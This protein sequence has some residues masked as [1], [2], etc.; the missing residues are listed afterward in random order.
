MV[1]VLITGASGLLGRA[2]HTSFL[3][4]SSSHPGE[5]IEV[6]GTSYT[7][8]IEGRDLKKCDLNDASEVENLLKEVGPEVVIHCAAERRPDVAEKNPEAVQKLNVALPR[9]LSHL[10]LSL[11]FYLIYISTDYVFPGDKLP[12]EGGYEPGDKVG[13]TNLYGQTKEA[14][15][16]AVL[17]NAKP[18]TATVFRVPVLYGETLPLTNFG[19][20]A[21]NILLQVT[22]EVVRG[23]KSGVGMD[24]WAIRYPTNVVDIGRVLVDLT[25]LSQKSTHQI[26]PTLHF[27]HTQPFTKYSIC[28][29]FS[30]L[31]TSLSS[32]GD[33]DARQKKV[34][35]GMKR[36]TEGPKEG[37]TKRPRD[38]RLANTE[39]KKL[40]IDT[41]GIDFA[42]WWKG[43]FEREQVF[44]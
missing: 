19:E 36:V 44:R 16:R 37:E 38:C 8:H 3:N 9:L 5:K 32:F 2:I 1:K 11:N 34:V 12:R 39:L 35:D 41:S 30:S 20:S 43:W 40:G 10:S 33:S 4:Y 27:S 28:L 14:G 29:L 22:R 23:D 21:I 13:P 26:P 25:L 17:E 42:D 24:D 6:I 15:E 18:G 7:R 31:D